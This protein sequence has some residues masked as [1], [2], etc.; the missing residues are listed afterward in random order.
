MELEIAKTLIGVGGTILGA[1]G[2]AV[3]NKIIEM[4]PFL[5]IEKDRRKCL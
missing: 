3:S 5:T 2:V 4:R 1:I